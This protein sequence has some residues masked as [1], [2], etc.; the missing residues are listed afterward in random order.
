MAMPKQKPGRSKQDYGTPWDF[1]WS[2]ER[3]LEDSFSWDLAASQENTKVPDHFYGKED[4]SLTK[5]WHELAGWLFLNPPYA[6]IRPWVQKASE[7]SKL[8][9]RVC[10][11]VPSST[12]ANWW[13]EYVD[14]TAYITFL[15]GRI[16]F[17]GTRD[18]YPKD[19]A[20]L[21]YAPYLEGGSC[22]WRWL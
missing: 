2:L 4:D 8:G 9:A 15:N 19:L 7:E 22:I 6:D 13:K 14:G 12:G 10:V 5:R 21:I 18:P 3:R 20:L 11:L 16:T 17:E 1:F